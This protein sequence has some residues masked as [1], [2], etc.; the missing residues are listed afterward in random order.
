MGKIDYS[1]KQEL[2]CGMCGFRC[3]FLENGWC[4]TCNYVYD[5]DEEGKVVSE[6]EVEKLF[7]GEKE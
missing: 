2:V 6:K 1:D 5:Q 3:G 4:I 7:G